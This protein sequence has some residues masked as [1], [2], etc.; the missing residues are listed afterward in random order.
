MYEDAL[1]SIEFLDQLDAKWL[2]YGFFK[3]VGKMVGG[4][5]GAG[6][7]WPILLQA[8]QISFYSLMSPSLTLF[9]EKAEKFSCHT[10]KPLYV[11]Q[12]A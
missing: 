1:L 9:A 6:E 11:K 5:G 3:F 2:S 7:Q 4:G 8:T 12:C 10:F